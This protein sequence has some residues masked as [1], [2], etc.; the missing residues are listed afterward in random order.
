MRRPFETWKRWLGVTVAPLAL[1][2]ALLGWLGSIEVLRETDVVVEESALE[3]AGLLPGGALL[4]GE[5]P[6]SPSA[7]PRA[8]QRMIDLES[9]VP[10]ILGIAATLSKQGHLAHKRGDLDRAGTYYEASVEIYRTLAP[11]GLDMATSLHDLGVLVLERGNL[12]R[13]AEYYTK[14]LKIRQKL[15][16]S[17]LDTATN[18]NNLGDLARHRGDF[19][20]A[21]E[22]YEEALDI[23][24]ELA[25]G[26]LDMATSLYNMG[27]VSFERDSFDQAGE[28]YIK[29]LKSRQELTP[30]SFDVAVVLG[31]LGHLTI[32]RGNLDLASDLYEWSM[33]IYQELAPSSLIL[34]KNLNALGK[35]TSQRGDLSQAAEYFEGALEIYQDLTPGSLDV[36]KNLNSLGRLASKQNDSHRAHECLK[37]SL[38]LFQKLTPSSLDVAENLNSLGNLT[39]SRRDIDQAVKW[40]L[41]AFS[42]R[43]E[44]GIL[45]LPQERYYLP[46]ISVHRR[47]VFDRAREYYE[48]ALEIRQ[49]LA[50]GSLSVAASLNNLGA[51]ARSRGDWG[52]A[53]EYAEA[54]LKIRQKLTPGSL[55]VAGGMFNLGILNYYL[56]DIDRAIECQEGA[57]EIYQKLAPDG[58]QVAV[59]LNGLGYLTSALG[60][61]DRATDYA[62]RF[63]V[64]R[65]KL[66]PDRV[67]WVL[68]NLETL[69][70]A[71]GDLNQAGKYLESRRKIPAA[72]FDVARS[73]KDLGDLAN[74]LGN[75]NRAAEYYEEALKILENQGAGSM[76]E[77]R[78]LHGLATVRRAQGQ[79]EAALGLFLRTLQ[80]FDQTLGGSRDG[81]AD[82]R[83]ERVTYYRDIIQVLLESRQPEEAF[84]ALERSRARS[85]LAQLAERDPVF[86]SV[87]ETLERERQ[88]HAWCSDWLQQEVAGLRP[89]K[90]N[91]KEIETLR[92]SL[93]GIQKKR[94]DTQEQIRQN[95]PNLAAIQYPEPLDLRDAQ[96]ALDPGTVMLS[97]SVGEEATYLFVVTS[98][99][100]LKVHS[101]SIGEKKLAGF[102]ADFHNKI[103]DQGWASRTTGSVKLSTLL[104][105]TLIEPAAAMVQKSDRVLIVPDGPLHRL[106][107]AALIRDSKLPIS[108]PGADDGARWNRDWHY[109]VE[110]KPLH[111]VLS[112]TVF[113]ERKELRRTYR[114]ASAGVPSIQLAA[115]GDPEYPG[116][117]DG[118]IHVRAAAK[119]GFEFSPLPHT[120]REIE[121]IASHFPAEAVRTYLG[122]EATEEQAKSFGPGTRILHFAT[123][124]NVDDRFPLNSFVVGDLRTRPY[125]R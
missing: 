102:V 81:P 29:A 63:L 80:H 69:A 122:A 38:E 17:S 109:L 59:I 31:S 97:Y 82:F 92:C 75:F 67:N 8:A 55:D 76:R 4:S 16:P 106:P 91:E 115:F 54:F 124:G 26:S 79:P 119:R 72:E 9:L 89:S 10:G 24:Q 19:D 85:F 125:Q 35:L 116:N 56:D 32:K 1:I 93:Q 58:P 87:P 121:G 28:Y 86:A 52:Q 47:R 83:A 88:L 23:Q 42:E 5:R 112:A 94:D 68:K 3:K 34:A 15:A 123:H 48:G 118:D 43:M 90:N 50:P 84:L 41:V 11:G 12:N 46:E 64:I 37:S 104:Y 14:S 103:H 20:Q 30:D 2:V 57:L 62:E 99:E 7:D 73:L 98:D 51:L 44:P 39:Y 22:Y 49:K 66:A 117:M 18:L 101:I 78:V 33:T 40:G 114:V 71:R 60:D 95:Y 74:D 27:V 107:F 113:A 13:A 36:A 61:L 53:A 105:K 111:T 100:P 6:P 77:A 120:R 21:A 70:V 96:K 110:W 65:Q 45:D 108:S 25:P